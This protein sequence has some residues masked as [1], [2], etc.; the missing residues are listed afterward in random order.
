LIQVQNLKQ[1]WFELLSD[2]RR[3]APLLR[4]TCGE[5]LTQ[6]RSST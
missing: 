3:T 4:G 2:G 5:C 1:T 6:Y